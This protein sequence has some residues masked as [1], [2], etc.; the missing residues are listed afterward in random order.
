M[1]DATGRS[2][3]RLAARPGEVRAEDAAA[4]LVLDRRTAGHGRSVALRE[5]EPL[6]VGRSACGAQPRF[7][8]PPRALE[9]KPAANSGRVRSRPDSFALPRPRPL[10]LRARRR[11][12]GDRRPRVARECAACS[13]AQLSSCS[14][15]PRSE[16]SQ[17]QRLPPISPTSRRSRSATRRSS[18][19]SSRP[20]SAAT[21]SRTTPWTSTRSS[22]RTPS[23]CAGRGTRPT[24]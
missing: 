8:A 4:R 3:Q 6:C 18:G 14:P 16:Q 15:A 20:R 7:I 21:A 24:S 5:R 9:M 1:V 10:R 22:A 19:S 12:S 13:A 2:G 23:R 11:G 17:R